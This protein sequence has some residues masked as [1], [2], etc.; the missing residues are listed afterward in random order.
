VLHIVTTSDGV[1]VS[2]VVKSSGLQAA[3][4]SAALKA[5]RAEGRIFM[6]GERRFARYAGSQAA[7]DR[8]SLAARKG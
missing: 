4:V 5:L 8:A 7:A 6:G 3:P 2:D 1:G